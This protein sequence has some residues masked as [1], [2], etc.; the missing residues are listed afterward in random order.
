MK[1]PSGTVVTTE[2]M[3]ELCEVVIREKFQL[4]CPF[5]EAFET[6]K[7]MLYEGTF[8]GIP[9]LH[10]DDI[11]ALRN[12]IMTAVIDCVGVLNSTLGTFL[13]ERLGEKPEYGT[14]T[15]CSCGHIA[16]MHDKAGKCGETDC[17][18]L[19][20]DGYCIPEEVKNETT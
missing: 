5:I 19:K 17:A 8:E 2:K 18:C 6:T 10:F 7:Q 1:P 16:Q 3:E 14:W 11:N 12:A 4:E 15:T 13:Q 20:Y 9:A